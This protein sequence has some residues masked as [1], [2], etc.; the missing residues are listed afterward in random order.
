MIQLQ[1]NAAQNQGFKTANLTELSNDELLEV[2][3]GIVPLLIIGAALLLGGCA[4]TR[5]VA[6]I[7]NTDSCDSTCSN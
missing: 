5:E 6:K 2:D 3:G 1:T 4:T 7:T